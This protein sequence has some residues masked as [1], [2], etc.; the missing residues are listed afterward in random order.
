MVDVQRKGGVN[1][2]NAPTDHSQSLP[3]AR[4]SRLNQFDGR[5]D[6]TD[7]AIGEESDPH[8]IC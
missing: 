8:L 7:R 2:C 5:P 3:W 6:Y 1:K 4:L